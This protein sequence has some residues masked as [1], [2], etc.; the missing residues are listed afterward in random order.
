[1]TYEWSYMETVA[2]MWIWVGLDSVTVS[3]DAICSWWSVLSLS[4]DGM[5]MLEIV[6]DARLHRSGWGDIHIPPTACSWLRV[7]LTYPPSACFMSTYQ[8]EF[9]LSSSQ[10]LSVIMKLWSEV[11]D[12][13]LE[14]PSRRLVWREGGVT[15]VTFHLPPTATHL[16][17]ELTL[18]S[19]ALLLISSD[20]PDE[21]KRRWG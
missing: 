20:A 14:S 15:K 2:H 19:H 1:V 7:T 5:R 3:S 4:R 10:V 21:V 13:G 12:D 16:L 11:M 8:Y 9:S 6:R 18:P 17:G